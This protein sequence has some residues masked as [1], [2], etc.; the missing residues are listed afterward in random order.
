MNDQLFSNQV[1]L[2][3]LHAGPLGSHIDVF[4]GVLSGRGYARSTLENH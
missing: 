4:A 1:L 3:H 2:Q